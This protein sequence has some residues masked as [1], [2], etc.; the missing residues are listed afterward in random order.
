MTGKQLYRRPLHI[1][2]STAA[3]RMNHEDL[4]DVPSS[5]KMPGLVDGMYPA[6]R[7]P[8]EYRV[9]LANGGR[10]AKRSGLSGVT[11][12]TGRPVL[13]NDCV[14]GGNDA[15]LAGTVGVTAHGQEEIC[16][17]SEL[18]SL[19]DSTRLV[20]E[21]VS[22]GTGGKL[23]LWM[24]ESGVVVTQPSES[25]RTGPRTDAKMRQRSHEAGAIERRR[26]D[27]G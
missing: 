22:T 17:T 16:I 26:C 3:D 21:A 2:S 13:P 9:E 23:W 12:G 14:E 11:G 10:L 25:P 5:V 19:L 6:P 20:C 8:L 7:I 4:A 18:L 24:V 15:G 27:S 1:N